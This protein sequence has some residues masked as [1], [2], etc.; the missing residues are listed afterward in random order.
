[1]TAAISVPTSMVPVVS[2]VTCTMQGDAAVFFAHDIEGGDDGDFG[3][4]EVEA[5]FDEEGVHA[6][7]EQAADLGGVGFEEGVGGDRADG[8]RLARGPT[9]P[10]TK[11]GWAGVA[12]R[13]AA[14]RA[15][16]AAVLFKR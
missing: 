8:G 1:M 7:V 4:E 10:A 11:R 14:R 15:I 6:A 5:G 12:K 9:E 16:W 3:L 2:M 13:G